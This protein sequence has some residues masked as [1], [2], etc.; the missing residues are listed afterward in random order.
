MFNRVDH[1]LFLF[2][3]VYQCLL[4]FTY[5][6]LCLPMFSTS[7]VY[8][9]NLC[10]LMNVYY[11]Y[12]FTRFYLRLDLFN[13]INPCLRVFT[14]VY[15]CLPL[16]PMFTRVYICDPTLEKGAYGANYDIEICER[17]DGKL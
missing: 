8:R 16:L 17:K 9:V 12:L 5:V 15:L 1:C 13:N 2:T 11:V 3:Y 10:I 6:Y 4:V 7:T 14:L